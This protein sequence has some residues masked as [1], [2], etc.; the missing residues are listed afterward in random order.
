MAQ[1]R[2][3]IDTTQ[4]IIAFHLTTKKKENARLTNCLN[5]IPLHTHVT[6]VSIFWWAPDI[7]HGCKK[8]LCIKCVTA[9]LLKIIIIAFHLS[10]TL[11]AV[12]IPSGT[13]DNN[14]RLP[15]LLAT[16][17]KPKNSRNTGRLLVQKGGN[18]FLI[19][20]TKKKGERGGAL[21]KSRENYCLIQKQFIL[22]FAN[23]IQNREQ[24]KEQGKL[25]RERRE[26]KEARAAK[27]FERGDMIPR[28]GASLFRN[29]QITPIIYTYALSAAVTVL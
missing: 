29:L 17:V 24:A 16:K 26:R 14:P 22:F 10:T 18:K 11:P 5:K 20:Q 3:N 1:P 8:I 7:P 21:T 27:G 9:P 15:W 13:Y 19:F 12:T 23:P 6:C 25:E 4:L 2:T 28:R